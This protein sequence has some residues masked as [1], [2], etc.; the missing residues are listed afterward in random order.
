MTP[1]ELLDALRKLA[2][3]AK[4][5]KREEGYE[6]EDWA[7]LAGDIEANLADAVTGVKQAIEVSG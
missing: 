2:E 1:K 6:D 4:T 5:L 7:G 3:E